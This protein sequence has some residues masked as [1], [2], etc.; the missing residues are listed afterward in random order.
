M[1]TIDD[2]LRRS[3]FDDICAHTRALLLPYYT[4]QVCCRDISRISAISHYLFSRHC[5]CFTLLFILKVTYV[6]RWKQIFVFVLFFNC[7]RIN[8]FI[9]LLRFVLVF[10]TNMS[11]LVLTSS[12]VV[13]G[14]V[15]ATWFVCWQSCA[16]SIR[17]CR[18]SDQSASCLIT[19]NNKLH[20]FTFRYVSP[21]MYGY[22]HCTLMR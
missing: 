14:A 10:S 2:V 18:T 7:N 20:A 1:S 3:R 11:L 8:F 12:R 16:C 9:V 21:L 19:I 17:L 5:Y 15:F 4:H 22:A 13:G 6:F